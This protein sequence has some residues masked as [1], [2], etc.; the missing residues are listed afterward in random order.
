MSR[1]EFPVV[2]YNVENLYDTIDDPVVKDSMFT[3]EGSKHWTMERYLKKISDVGEVLSKAA[4]EL[5]AIIGVAEIENDG[6]LV[7]LLSKSLLKNKNYAF[8]HEHSPDSRGIDVAF[9]YDRDVFEY[10]E[11]E[12][13]KVEF[14]W[15]RAIKTRDILRVTGNLN[16]ERIHFVI[17]HWPSRNKG[18]RETEEKRLHTAGYVRRKLEHIFED[19]DQPNIVVMGDFNDEPDNDS[20]QVVLRSKP[21]ID[22]EWDEFYNVMTEEYARG[23][24]TNTYENE[25]LMLDQFHLSKPLL[26]PD[27][28][29]TLR[30][31]H[32]HIYN[33]GDVIFNFRNGFS[34][35]NETYTG[36]TYHGGYSDHLAIWMVLRSND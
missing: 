16:G 22:I 26:D 34:K 29:L 24:G 31:Q 36:D 33:K 28:G 25:W 1:K 8:V 4:G 10:V 12:S 21:Y 13:F 6:V 7:D 18:I 5:P 2:F 9:I 30:V 32:S 27:N 17:N 35:P 20:I 3:P 19:E 11:H 23:K 14:E 15:N